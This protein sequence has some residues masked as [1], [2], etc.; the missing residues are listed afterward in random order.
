M[1]N[2]PAF[3]ASDESSILSARTKVKTVSNDTVFTLVCTEI[4]LSS[5]IRQYA[6]SQMRVRRSELS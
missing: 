4:E 2:I 1:A 5:A 6:K 3:Q